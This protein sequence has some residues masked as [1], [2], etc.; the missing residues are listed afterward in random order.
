[1]ITAPGGGLE[2]NDL[3]TALL[4]GVMTAAFLLVI[5]VSTRKNAAIAGIVIPLTLVA[6]HFAIATLTGA[7]VN[8]ARSIGP[9]VLAAD[10]GAL[11]IYIVG[12]IV[13]AV[14]AWGVYAFAFDKD[15][16]AA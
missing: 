15:E 7:S 2:G 3:G 8:P 13:G 11:W 5:L 10:F 16:E 1:V 4:E 9:A 6:I 14:V 12:P